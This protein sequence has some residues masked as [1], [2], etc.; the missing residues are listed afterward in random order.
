MLET[1]LL[2][3]HQS[4]DESNSPAGPIIAQ[5]A[6]QNKI[7]FKKIIVTP[8]CADPGPIRVTL[9]SDWLPASISTSVTDSYTSFNDNILR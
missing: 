1:Q 8:V 5:L 6:V 9:F 2:T 3:K 4:E 7:R